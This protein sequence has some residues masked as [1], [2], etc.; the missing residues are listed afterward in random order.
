[1]GDASLIG[2]SGAIR[3]QFELRRKELIQLCVLW[4]KSLDRIPFD[5][6]NLPEWGPTREELLECQINDVTASWGDG[7]DSEE[8]E[9]EED[10]DDDGLFETLAA[11]ERADLHRGG[12]DEGWNSDDPF[13]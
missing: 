9:E 8:E 10:D 12:E 1:M 2:F 6:A 7:Y 3:Y 11:V 4:K 5:E 13:E